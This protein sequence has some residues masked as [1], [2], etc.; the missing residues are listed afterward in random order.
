MARPLHHDLHFVFPCL[1]SEIA[2]RAELRRLRRAS[3]APP[4]LSAEQGI[5][6]SSQFV[7]APSSIGRGGCRRHP[8]GTRWQTC[9]EKFSDPAVRIRFWSRT[10]DIDRSSTRRGAPHASASEGNGSSAD[11]HRFQKQNGSSDSSCIP[12]ICQIYTAG[13]RCIG[14]FGCLRSQFAA[15]GHGSSLRLQNGDLVIAGSNGS[16]RS[17]PM[18]RNC[19][20]RPSYH[21]IRY[22]HTL[23]TFCPLGTLSSSPQPRPFRMGTTR[24]RASRN[25]AG[26]SA[27]AALLC[28]P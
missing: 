15:G 2:Q 5:E 25:R 8:E 7:C 20:L 1:E 6:R 26:N 10:H 22:P 19:C 3:F 14:R 18:S 4:R 12:G 27:E 24:N 9:C 17:S 11:Q 28:S 16:C 21:R 23:R 13:I